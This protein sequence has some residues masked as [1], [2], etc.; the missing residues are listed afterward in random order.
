MRYFPPSVV[1]LR[2]MAWIMLVSFTSVM[3]TYVSRGGFSKLISRSAWKYPRKPSFRRIPTPEAKPAS[4]TD[5]K[6]DDV[7][8]KAIRRAKAVRGP[9]GAFRIAESRKDNN[10]LG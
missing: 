3:L 8:G 9:D 4:R 10:A 5:A 2:K 1:F 6:R 7:R